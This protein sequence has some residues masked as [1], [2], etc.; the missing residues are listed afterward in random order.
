MLGSEREAR[1]ALQ[2]QSRDRHQPAARGLSTR[3]SMPNLRPR[4]ITRSKA[5]VARRPSRES[6]RDVSWADKVSALEVLLCAADPEAWQLGYGFWPDILEALGDDDEQDPDERF[7]ISNRPTKSK[8][9]V[10]RGV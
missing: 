8:R 10:F 9:A 3:N 5:R 2:E 7:F 4:S 6:V 1:L